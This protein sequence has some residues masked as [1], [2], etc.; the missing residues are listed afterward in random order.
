MVVVNETLISSVVS[1]LKEQRSKSRWN[2]IKT[3]YPN[4]FSPKEVSEITLRIKN[5]PRL[6]LRFFLW[7]ERKALCTHDLISY[8]TIIHILARSRLKTLSQTLIQSA[9]RVSEPVNTDRPP[10]IFET[11]TKTYRQC[12]SAPFV[13]DLLIRACLESKKTDQT[14]AIV[15]LLRSQGI[16]PTIGTCNLLLK[17]VSQVKGS[18]SCLAIYKEIFILDVAIASRVKAR[19]SANVQTLNILMLAFYR[20]G[21]MEKVVDIWNEM[22]GSLSFNGQPNVFSYSVLLAT[23]CDQRKI[24]EAMRLWEGMQSKGIKADVTSYNTLIKGLCENRDVEK[25][26]EIFREMLLN[27]IHSTSFTYEHLIRGYCE[28]GDID[29][30]ILLYRDMRKTEGFQPEAHIVE[31]MIRALCEKSRVSEA[32]DLFRDAMKK[33][34]F[35]ATELSYEVLIRGLC[36]EGKIDDALKLQSEMV[37]R[38]FELNVEMYKVF[39][40]AYDKQGNEEKSR[41]LKKEM[42]EFGLG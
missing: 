14:I 39:I 21:M 28:I 9:M 33:N 8:S 10:K 11:L 12:D 19:V 7:S 30:A 42:D 35:F 37:G 23:L 32:M 6:A 2:F 26:E 38:G 18:D 22:M 40:S 13:F 4:G 1:I 5:N 36:E 16:F 15:R 27:Q 29:S 3:L 34:D 17:S 31:E 24:T 20:D 41:E 25:A